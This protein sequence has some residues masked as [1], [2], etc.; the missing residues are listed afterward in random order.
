[1]NARP[2]SQAGDTALTKRRSK[3]PSY[4]SGLSTKAHPWALKSYGLGA[5]QAG[6]VKD[7]PHLHTPPFPDPGSCSRDGWTQGPHHSS[8]PLGDAGSDGDFHHLSLPSV[9][10]LAQSCVS[11]HGH[12]CSH[13]VASSLCPPCLQ[14]VPPAL[15][16]WV[17]IH[18]W[19][20]QTPRVRIHL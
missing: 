20:S 17:R 4:S 2:S 18:L 1:M 19:E 9:G 10:H 8:Q 12:P 6:S 5:G 3:S 16:S 7:F 15:D 14:L 13:S 11:Q